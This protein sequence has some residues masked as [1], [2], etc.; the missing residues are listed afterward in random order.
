MQY[1]NL[2]NNR[3]CAFCK[4]WYDPTNS[5]IMPKHPTAGIWEY[6]DKIESICQKT[7]FKRKSFMACQDY[8][9]KIEYYK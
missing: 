8:V 4:H 2:K 3:R 5:A 1:H 9:C 7:G 6:D